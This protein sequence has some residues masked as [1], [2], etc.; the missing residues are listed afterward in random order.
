MQ[1]P[2]SP[3]S[4]ANGGTAN[5]F[6]AQTKGLLGG[7]SKAKKAG[8]KAKGSPAAMAAS[9]VATLEASYADVEPLEVSCAP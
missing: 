6:R 2:G 7:G 1:E 3:R 8:D 5:G 4:R 9:S